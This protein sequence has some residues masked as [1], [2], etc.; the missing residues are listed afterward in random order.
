MLV[1]RSWLSC[2]GALLC[3]FLLNACATNPLNQPDVSNG[4]DGLVYATSLN[5]K[6]WKDVVEI[7]SVSTQK[8]YQ[9]RVDQKGRIENLHAW[10]PPG[11]YQLASWNGAKFPTYESFQVLSRRVADLGT[12]TPIQTGDYKFVVLPLHEADMEPA[13][14]ALHTTYPGALNDAAATE[15][16]P[17]TMPPLLVQPGHYPGGLIQDLI[18]SYSRKLATPP[19]NASLTNSK[20]VSNFLGVAGA[21]SPPLTQTG[22]SGGDGDLYYGA[23]LGEIRARRRG[24]KWDSINT[25]VIHQVT[26]IGWNGRTLVAGYDNGSIR[27]SDDHG[28]HWSPVTTLPSG[29]PVMSLDWTGQRWIVET[30]AGLRSIANFLQGKHVTIYISNNSSLSSFTQIYNTGG[31][32]IIVAR[33]Q[34]VGNSYYVGTGVK[35]ACLDLRTMKWSA[36]KLPT[37]ASGFYFNKNGRILTVFRS[38]GIF[39]SVYVSENGGA[40]WRET[41]R[42]PMILL[43]VKYTSPT[44]GV[45]LQYDMGLNSASLKIYNYESASKQWKLQEPEP[46]SSCVWFVDDADGIP[47]YCVTRG[48]DI[49]A[50]HDNKWQVEA[51]ASSAKVKAKPGAKT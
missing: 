23:A 13:M 5:S 28:V 9:L 33:V 35:L 22:V 4:T 42:P 39:S 44:S 27:A 7:R 6:Q 40:S 18:V 10:V 29:D 19:V 51:A 32:R 8:T 50:K 49:L 31:S 12:L 24:G 30:F 21:E 2:S 16:R 46:P 26:A 25:G 20:S 45:A 14:A 47:T 34:L 11:D 48:W 17:M 38:S 43:D 36:I 1:R 41:A 3:A 15:W 37:F